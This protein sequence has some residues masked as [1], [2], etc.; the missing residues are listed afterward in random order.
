MKGKIIEEF[1]VRAARNNKDALTPG[2][3][4]SDCWLYKESFIKG[5]P[6]IYS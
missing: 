1:V 3:G 2:D 4:S 6:N 5:L